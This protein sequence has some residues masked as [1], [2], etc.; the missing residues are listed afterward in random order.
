MVR[1]NRKSLTFQDAVKASKTYFSTM[2]K[3]VGSLCNLDCSYC[4]YLDKAD[5]YGGRQ[6]VMDDRLLE[7]YVRQYI[8]TNDA[9]EVVFN[10]HGGEPLI[11]GIPFYEKAVRFQKKYAGG[12]S[13]A[14]NIQTNG[15][16][17]DE[18][19]CGFFRDNAFLVGVSIDGPRDIHDAFRTDKGGRPTFDRVVEAVGMLT[20]AGVE[21]NT[22]TTVN[23]LGEGR[24]AEVYRFLK[25][26]G[27]RF[28]QFLPVVEYVRDVPG[29]DRPVIVPPRS[30]GARPAPWS[31]SAEGFGRFMND[32]F[33]EWVVRDVGSYY[34]QLFDVLLAQ[35]AG[36]PPALC[37]FAETCG[38]A[39]VVEHNGDIYCCDHFVYPEYRLGNLA[40]TTLAAAK[41]SQKNFG[42]GLGKRESLPPECMRCGWYFACRGECPKHRFDA[43]SDGSPGM[44]A[45]CAG[46]KK[47]F[48]HVDPYMKFM[49]DLLTRRQPPAFVMPFAWQR[50]G[51][52]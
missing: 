51:L 29:S 43:A 30:E 39:L 44:N 48:S 9:P 35:W 34:V 40:D 32:V 27:S 16:L 19:W 31:V 6:P 46:Y 14:N 49:A 5:L 18:K 15:I 17:V 22:L 11:A 42:F 20:S 50:M 28:M 36:E 24:G 1:K 47:I 3:P 21:L 52:F 7:E 33:D 26:I 38:D 37:S 2:A 41:R 4:Y 10:W 25:K 8:E 45:L 23:R 13:V 12:K